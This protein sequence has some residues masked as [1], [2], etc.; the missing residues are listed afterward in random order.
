MT[1]KRGRGK[2]WIL[3]RAHIVSSGADGEVAIALTLGHRVFCCAEA[4]LGRK[5]K[6]SSAAPFGWR[7][8]GVGLHHRTSC[9]ARLGAGPTR[10]DLRAKGDFSSFLSA[11]LGG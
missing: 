9:G 7:K 6:G 5:G 2:G 11:A 10:V 4:S 8:Q 1:C 3:F